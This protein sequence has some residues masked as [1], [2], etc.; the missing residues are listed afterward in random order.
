MKKYNF[1]Q[2]I[3]HDLLLGNN[4]LKKTCFEFEKLFFSRK[5]FEIDD[6]QHL[7]ITGLP[8]CG[9]T[10]LLNFFFKTEQFGSLTYEDLPF[11]MAPN[12]YSKFRSKKM[13][14]DT[15]NRLH[16]DGIEMSLKSPEAF[17]EVF[18]S[19]FED[20][21]IIDELKNYI[22]LILI[23]KKKKRYLS[24]NNLNFKRINLISQILPSSKFL[25]AIREPLQHCYSLLK[26]HNNFLTLQSKDSFMRR[27]MKYLS[28]NEFGMDHSSWFNSK[29]YKDFNEINYWLEQWLFFYENILKKFK[30]HKNC[31]IIKYENLEKL[32]YINKVIKQLDLKEIKE[33]YFK[34]KKYQIDLKYDEK[35]LAKCNEIYELI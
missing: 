22:K 8:R 15:I 9:T 33:N 35:L 24:K 27:Y 1:I 13:R 20:Q 16:N 17:D 26:Q 29:D 18:F 4:F 19:T 5:K 14:I 32:D 10:I 3:L 21:E 7:F 34:I 30:Q 12:L 2:K 23:N 31:I 6:R 28:H 25:I 11:L